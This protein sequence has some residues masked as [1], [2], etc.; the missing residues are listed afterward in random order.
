[1]DRLTN[2]IAEQNCAGCNLCALACSFFNTDERVFNPSRAFIQ[3]E[4]K[5]GQNS[6]AVNFK[7]DCLDC[8]T[9][10]EYCHYGVL[11]VE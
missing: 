3:I 11:S 10:A 7:E 1:M 6:F 9:C 5:D 8:G 4:R 2:V